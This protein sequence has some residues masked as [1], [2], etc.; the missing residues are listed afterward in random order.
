M[1]TTG[2]YKDNLEMSAPNDA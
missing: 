2:I 1:V